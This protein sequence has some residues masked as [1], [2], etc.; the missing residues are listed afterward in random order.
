MKNSH[1]ILLTVVVFFISVSLT[2]GETQKKHFSQISS[3]QGLSH[4]TVISIVQ[5]KNDLMWFA[6]F[7]GLNRF[8]GYDFK[9]YRNERGNDKSLMHDVLRVLFVDS[10]GLLWIGNK[11]GLSLYVSERDNFKN[12]HCPAKKDQITQVNAIIEFDNSHL[13]T[14]TET[15]L[16]LFDKKNEKFVELQQF[17]T[18]KKQVQSL[19]KQGNNFLIGTVDGLYV[20]NN[21]RKYLSQVHKA[22]EGKIIQAILPQS[23]SRIWIGTEGS[24]LYLLNLTT[25]EVKNYRHNPNDAGSLSSDYIRSLAF[26]A[27]FN[28]WIGTFNALSIISNG[29]DK[30]TNYYHNPT[31]EGSISQNSIRSVY[32]DTQGGMWLGSYYGGINYYHPL[33]NKFEHLQQNPYTR[34]LNDKVI[35]CIVE[36]EDGRMWIGANDMGINVYHPNSGKFDYF[37]RSNTPTLLSNNIKAFLLS[38]DKKSIYVGTHSGGLLLMNKTTGNCKRINN[39]DRSINDVYTLTYD[40]AGNIWIGTLDGLYIYNESTGEIKQINISEMGSEQVLFLKIDSHKRIWIGGEKSLGMLKNRDS[41]LIVF[42]SGD[43]NGTVINSAINCIFEDS[44]KRIWIGTRGGLNLYNENGKFKLYNKENGLPGNLIYGILE[45]SFGRLWISTNNGISCFT[46]E[47]GMFRNYSEADDLLFSQY[48]TYSFCQARSGLMY[49]GGINGITT[50]YPELLIDNPHTPQPRIGKIMIQNEEVH[51]FDKTG[52][53]TKNILDTK[54]ITLKASQS[55]LTIEFFVSNYLSGRHNTF[56]YKL[57]GL[58]KNWNQSTENRQVTYTNLHHGK[59]VFR[60]KAAN[61]DGKWNEETTDLEIRILP[62]WWQTWWAILLFILAAGITGWYIHRFMKQ[63][64]AMDEQLRAERIEKEKMEEINQMKTRFFIN[65]S[66]E[67]RT[68]LTLILSPLQEII[69]RT[70]DKWQRSQLSHIQKNTGKLLRLVNQLMD[71]RRAELGF[72]ELRVCKTNA[73]KQALEI[74]NLFEKLAKRKKINYIFEDFAA[75]KDFLIDS[76]YLEL[77]LS[78]LLSNAFKFTPDEGKIIVRLEEDL[79]Y[80]IVEVEDTG[81]GI[82]P[83]KQALI[84]DRFYQVNYDNMGTGIGLS[85]VKRLV[86]SHH[87][88]IEVKST[89]EVGSTF[90]LY[91]P[92]NEE[93]YDSLEI[94]KH[95]TD[96]QINIKHDE[97][98]FI[99]DDMNTDETE[100]EAPDTKNETLLIVEDNAEVTE[101]LSER[102]L[103]NYN[104]FTAS[105]GAEALEVLR[106]KEIDLVLTDVMMPVMDGIKLCKSIKQ[107]IKTCH[108]PVIILSAKSNTEDQLEGLEVGADDYLPKPFTYSVLKAKIQNMLKSRRRS[109]EHYSKTLEVEPEKITFNA[110]DEELLKK[111]MKIVLNNLD[112]TE[113]STDIFCSEMGMSRSNLHLKLKAITGESTIDFIKKIRFNEACKLLLN[114]KYNVAEVSTM[115]GFNTPSYFATSFRKYF[116]C[117]PTDYVKSRRL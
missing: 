114:G 34:S 92:Q 96:N 48:N 86:D 106:N 41:R 82:P 67:F 45:D 4:N 108:I 53:L 68:P 44:K 66:H 117:L 32:M 56:A 19:A 102:L 74:Y 37:T 61:N 39:T 116:G 80:F 29:G 54:K 93:M 65:I 75:D 17:T 31:Q 43:Y 73:K 107:N 3:Q 72:F 111:A 23:D 26:D 97:L 99:L 6:T 71:Y 28:L 94:D 14:G 90:T 35:S 25:G 2:A 112:N 85:L 12:Y 115:V 49:F 24:G 1:F 52:I 18:L 33:K 70:T 30:F 113:F 103:K 104:I 15:G 27:Q 8:N 64:Q 13:L 11:G 60:V 16:Y 105:N 46:P 38:K 9:V 110:M 36:D 87:G 10:E 7:D 109:L 88:K 59:Y 79:N 91:I 20:Y 101:Y 21:S 22:F 76:N 78:N 50:F 98:G 5:D 55:S 83:D 95:I 51:P 58:D 69:E 81:C 89:P 63:R 57:E 42:H 100:P 77:I 40:Q 62:H 47:T 84:F